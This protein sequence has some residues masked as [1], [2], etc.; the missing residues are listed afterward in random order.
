[1]KDVRFSL[2]GAVRSTLLGVGLV[3]ML[4]SL[5]GCNANEDTTTPAAAVPAS[6]PALTLPSTSSAVVATTRCDEGEPGVARQ[7]GQCLRTSRVLGVAMG[8]AVV[9]VA[10]PAI[11]DATA[12]M[13]WAETTYPAIF[14]SK[15]SNQTFDP[16]VYRYYPETG[17]YLGV[18]A[19]VVYVLGPITNNQLT[20]V[21]TLSDFACKVY[22]SA[23]TVADTNTASV[24]KAA[25]DFAATLSATQLTALNVTYSLA[26]AR[27]W[28]NLPAAMVPRNGVAYASLSAAQQTAAKALLDTALSATGSKLHAD[29]RIAD[30]Q[31]LTLGASSSQYGDG[32][33]YI[34]FLGTPST[35][36]KWILQITGH[37][38]TYNLAYNSVYRS[39]TPQFVAVEPNLAFTYNG[40]SYDPLAAQRT[41]IGNL[42]TALAAYPAAKLTGTY[43]DVLFG[44]NGTGGIDGT[45]PKAYP[46]GSSNRG[47]LFSA[48]SV[49]DQALVKAAVLSY[50][51][52][53]ATEVANELTAAY[54]SDAALAQTYVA[55]ATGTSVATRGNYFRIDGPRVWIEW[56]VQGGII[57]RNDIHPHSIWRDKVA[58][59]GG[60]F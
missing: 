46:T 5:P 22:A 51:N 7:A 20:S 41:A 40:V 35:S 38:L 30:N 24:V 26:K 3:S 55:Y 12:L 48:L 10:A 47:V 32:N 14:P 9:S 23:C 54:F 39:P 27:Q 25:N 18:A 16:Y 60:D 11:P 8:K 2:R 28:S 58:D 43:D 44:A 42:G 56:T 34:A 37:H 33:Y 50:V 13:D 19:S 53:Q 59:Y 31:L 17:T 6:P 52:T 21:G 57:V 45:M 29:I 1:M 15:Q 36:T 4:L 49:A